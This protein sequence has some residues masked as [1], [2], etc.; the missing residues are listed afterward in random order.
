[1]AEENSPASRAFSPLRAIRKMAFACLAF[2]LSAS[3]VIDRI[4]PWLGARLR[5][6][7]LAFWWGFAMRLGQRLRSRLRGEAPDKARIQILPR[8]SV[9]PE[10]IRIAS[11]DDPL[12]SV[13]VPTYGQVSLTLGCLASIQ[14]HM[15]NASIEVIVVDDA[16]PGEEISALSR[17]SG[18]RLLRNAA[19]LGF[20][21]SCNAAA[22]HA[23]GQFIHFL[24]NDCEVQ[25]GW[26]DRLLDVF[27]A[28]PD[29]GI[30][31]SKLLGSDGLLQEAGGILWR[32]GSGWNYGSG[33]DPAAAEFNYLREVD[34]C[35]GASILL[36]RDVFLGMGGFDD[37]Y[38]PAYC[39]DSDLAFRLR[40]LG[41]KTYYQ[42]RS[43]ILHFEGASHG[44]DLTQGIKA[45]QVINQAKFLGTWREVLGRDH[46]LNASHV[47]RAKD[48]AHDRQVVLIIDHYLPE[49][50]RDAGSRTMLA[51]V[52]ALLASGLVVK[53]WPLNLRAS[54]GYTKVLQN[55]GVEVFYGADQMP[56]PAWLKENG[57]DLD[58]VL[59]S[60]PDVALQCLDIVRS[61][62]RARVAYYG[63]D[64]H[65]RR[66]ATMEDG[67][68]AAQAMRER[69]LSIWRQSDVVLYPSEEEA[70][71]VRAMAPDVN[72]RAVVPYALDAAT[73][74][75]LELGARDM[76]ILFVG[77]F[78]HSPNAQAAVW[79]VREVLPIVLQQAPQ[80]RMAIV[81]S[82]P[83]ACVIALGGANVSLFPNVSDDELQAWYRKARVAV[84]PL[85]AGAGVKMKTV[86]A[87]WHGLPA[88]MTPVGA[89]GLPDI[90][91]VAAVETDA[92]AFG[93]AVVALLTDDVLWQQ[94]RDVQIAYARE[95]FSEAALR[96]SLLDVLDVRDTQAT[97]ISAGA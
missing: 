21:R 61:V 4:S 45:Y 60:R 72:V 15:P 42:P 46:Y 86:E 97:P 73:E 40:A 43:E 19:N 29:A 64:L 78:A 28:R 1:M 9:P 34:Y 31:G 68:R 85:L 25:P 7:V 26:L 94:R 67:Q 83:A 62:T 63:H 81:G 20:L 16:F 32:D 37:Q 88:V 65:F 36:R 77:G 89:Q 11:S 53:F 82:N 23:R 3:Y 91:D 44:R 76:W 12:V 59:L 2:V 48:R 55:M 66:M 56:L 58:V 84:I 30:V 79:F 96:R 5:N 93:A 13:I 47:L 14:D 8:P 69:E 24:N 74:A 87:L 41:L 75:G 22:G 71:V 18:I 90:E 70:G 17:V 27:A 35:S 54:P 50:D 92:A 52:R 80:A 57:R 6:I 51:F 33:R 38:A 39:E 10:D 49:P 95:R